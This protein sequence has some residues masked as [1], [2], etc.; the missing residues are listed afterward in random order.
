M[1]TVPKEWVK[2]ETSRSG[3]VSERFEEEVHADVGAVKGADRAYASALEAAGAFISGERAKYLEEPRP[4]DP[5]RGGGGQRP[6]GPGFG[7]PVGGGSGE[8]DVRPEELAERERKAEALR[9]AVD[10]VSAAFEAQGFQRA[11]GPLRLD[12]G[13]LIGVLMFAAA[14]SPATPVGGS[15]TSP[16]FSVRQSGARFELVIAG[17]RVS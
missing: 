17:T 9:V 13:L 2:V 10:Q 5:E 7:K 8:R 1:G 12:F 3:G 4:D 15:V 11:E 14:L 16:P 6:L